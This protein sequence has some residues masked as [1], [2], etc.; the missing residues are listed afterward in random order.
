MM[1]ARSETPRTQP[2]RASF[3]GTCFKAMCAYVVFI[4]YARALGLLP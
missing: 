3:A 1:P 2:G 4:E